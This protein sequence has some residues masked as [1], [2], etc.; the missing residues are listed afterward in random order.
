MGIWHQ[1]HFLR[2]FPIT[3]R[4]PIEKWK[5]KN[6]VHHEICCRIIF[7]VLRINK[8]FFSYLKHCT[9]AYVK[10]SLDHFLKILPRKWGAQWRTVVVA[11]SSLS[12]TPLLGPSPGFPSSSSHPLSHPLIIFL[13]DCYISAGGF[14]AGSQLNRA[15]YLETNLSPIPLSFIMLLPQLWRPGMWGLDMNPRPRD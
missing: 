5:K 15:A 3:K 11:S 2:F 6:A 7:W 13:L 9:M 12:P 4:L 10:I 8:K 14:R 1:K